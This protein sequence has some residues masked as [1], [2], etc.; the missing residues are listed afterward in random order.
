VHCKGYLQP[1]N[2]NVGRLLRYIVNN[3]FPRATS[4]M[5]QLSKKIFR[6]A[7]FACI[8]S[9]GS[10]AF[11]Q[12]SQ[13]QQAQLDPLSEKIPIALVSAALSLITGYILLQVKERR[14]PRK[15]L[16]YDLEIRPGFVTAEEGVADKISITYNG[17]PAENLS[18]IRFNIR[19]TGT[20]VVKNEFLRFEFSAGSQI[21]D[22]YTEPTPPS[23]YGVSEITA[24][25]LDPNQRKYCVSHLEKTQA[26]GFRFILAGKSDPDPKLFPFNEEGD[27]EVTAA[28]VSR[29]ADD[30][31]IAV[32]FIQLF[33]LSLIVPPMLTFLP[34]P[35]LGIAQSI[36]YMI[37]G[38][39]MLPLLIPF[40]RVLSATIINLA[41]PRRPSIAIEN[42][43]QERGAG[44]SIAGTGD[45]RLMIEGAPTMHSN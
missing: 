9:V 21:L 13:V 44:I 10:S 25:L 2:R 16:S 43:H 3:S 30:G 42:L 11:A 32:S 39:G 1:L 14:E 7:C 22:A 4:K 18:Y 40:S 12:A 23:E 45:A 38:I 26:V 24:P 29:A 19:N 33:L 20:K 37:I 5:L 8:S 36:A 17:Q 27:V 34:Y 35:F 15:R 28:S 31:R 6:L 41:Q